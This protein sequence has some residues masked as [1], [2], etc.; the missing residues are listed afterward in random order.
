[1]IYCN[2]A[3]DLAKW[4]ANKLAVWSFATYRLLDATEQFEALHST[5]F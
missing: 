4:H 1:M 3:D 5:H 2:V